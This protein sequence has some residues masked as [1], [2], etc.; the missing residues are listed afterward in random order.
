VQA[1]QDLWTERFSRLD[2]V[3]TELKDREDKDDG[4]RDS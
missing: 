4:S 3:L 2:T 1:Y